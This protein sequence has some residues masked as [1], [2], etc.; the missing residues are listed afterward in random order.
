MGIE[1]TRNAVPES[2]KPEQT[3]YKPVSVSEEQKIAEGNAQKESDKEAEALLSA[4]F[5][6]AGLTPEQKA[7]HPVGKA[8]YYGTPKDGFGYK[9]KTTASGE[10]FV[11]KALTAAHRGLDFGTLVEVTNR[12]NG[13]KVIV[14]INDRGPYEG[15]GT[16]PR[17]QYT[18]QFDLALGAFQAIASTDT[19]VIDASFR[20]VSRPKA[21]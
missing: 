9:Y 4:P 19:G 13:K 10:T 2:S 6:M 12:A 17:R 1:N 7:F 20:I 5:E 14:R 15:V 3:P 21:A 16:G 8:S 11:P 18:R